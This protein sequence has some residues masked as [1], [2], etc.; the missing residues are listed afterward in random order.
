M[1]NHLNLYF[2]VTTI[3]SG[4]R[5]GYTNADVVTKVT[6]ITTDLGVAIEKF[7][8]KKRW[9][10]ARHGGAH[11][12][13]EV[14]DVRIELETKVSGDLIVVAIESETTRYELALGGKQND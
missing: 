2:I 3:V 7:Q 11:I 6:D 14:E 12:L 8:K 9:Q 1:K 13:N 5:G 4:F 10:L